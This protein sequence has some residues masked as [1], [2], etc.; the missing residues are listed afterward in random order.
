M[1]IGPYGRVSIGPT[2]AQ[3]QLT[4]DPSNYSP[5]V[6]RKRQSIH[7]G[8]GGSL[9]VQDFGITLKDQTVEIKG[10]LEQFMENSVVASV[11]ALFKVKGAVYK[12]TDW[13]DNEFT[14]YIEEFQPVPNRN[15]P[16]STYTIKCRILGCAKLFGSAYTGS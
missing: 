5:W 12:L 6:W 2:G 9:T 7:P 8:V 16:G 4:A 10:E 15:V 3:I 1:S 13:L 11:F 14:V